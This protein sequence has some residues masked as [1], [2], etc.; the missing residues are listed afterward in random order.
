MSDQEYY[1]R[2]SLGFLAPIQSF[3]EDSEVSEILINRPEE[4][5]VE[6]GGAMQRHEVKAFTKRH[7]DHLFTLIANENHQQLSEA[8]PL[9]SGSL[10]DG[11]RVQLVLPPTAKYHTLSIRRQV[12]QNFQLTDYLKQDYFAQAKGRSIGYIDPK[13]L[14][15]SD[16]MLMEHYA[17][18]DFYGF[19]QSAVRSRKNIVISGGTSSGKTTFANACLQ[20]VDLDDRV[21]VLEDTR[22]ITIPHTNKVQLLASK[23][24]QGVAKVNMQDLV[25][26]CLRLRPERIIMGEIRGPEIM[27]FV[28]ACSTGHEGSITTIHANSPRGAFFRMAQM[29][30][31]NNVPSMSDRDILRELDEVIDIIIQIGKTP[32]GR[33]MQSVYYRYGALALDTNANHYPSTVE[34][35]CA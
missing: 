17:K 16:Q 14:P 12:V 5:W 25:Q 29:Y 1:Q 6:K 3:L 35:L 11:S 21:I 7:L 31:I 32:T 34:L 20:E 27:D 2:G 15:E 10:P 22:E 30:K 9:F 18:N 28:S 26:C 8:N 19:V 4:I 24:E 23:G 33:K 13:D